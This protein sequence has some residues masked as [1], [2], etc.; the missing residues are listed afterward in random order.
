VTV[1]AIAAC[2]NNTNYQIGDDVNSDRN[3][4]ALRT[5]KHA[6]GE[7]KVVAAPKRV[8]VLD[9][10][11]LDS[12]LALG[13]KPIGTAIYDR[14]PSYLS[15]RTDGI[16]NVGIEFQPSL[17]KILL[18]KPDLIL[19]NKLSDRAIYD[20]LSRI[21][22][23]I[24]AEGSGWEGEWKENLKVYAE[25]LGKTE[26]AEELLQKYER[27]MVEFKEL[28]G[29]Q[30]KTYISV[31]VAKPEE[32]LIYTT[33]SFPGSVLRDAGLPRPPTQDKDNP[34]IQLSLESISVIE[35]DAIFLVKNNSN[36]AN[37]D[38]LIKFM[39]HPLWTQLK[40]VQQGK[41]YPVDS[42]TWI[43]GR[44]ILAANSILDDLFKYL[45]K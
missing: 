45:I 40:A 10:A 30:V 17:E 16:A 15:D 36:I 37:S 43:A 41:I 32:V 27:R 33:S 22:P 7:T 28:I 18:L 9:N 11:A 24:F 2:S 3:P 31:V 13:I 19:S 5:V 35:G 1:L 38:T 21:A 29:K 12:A 23:T 4:V 8:V 14:L 34:L 44:S 39:N 26:A 6:M 20:Q 25:A 42:D